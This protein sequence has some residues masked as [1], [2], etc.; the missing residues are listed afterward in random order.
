MSLLGLVLRPL[1]FWGVSAAEREALRMSVP[2]PDVSRVFTFRIPSHLEQ[3]LE[4][5]ARRD[6]NTVSATVRRLITLGL[7]TE[8][9]T[10]DQDR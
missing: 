2:T 6:A 5:L 10:G 9:R 1:Y 7:R 3:Q 4:S 8:L